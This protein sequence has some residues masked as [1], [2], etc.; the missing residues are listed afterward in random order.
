[1]IANGLF[2]HPQIRL[3][4]VVQRGDGFPAAFDARPLDVVRNPALMP[5]SAFLQGPARLLNTDRSSMRPRVN[6]AKRLGL[7]TAIFMQGVMYL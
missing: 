1:M 7:V 6:P 2:P 3:G 5:P 4:G